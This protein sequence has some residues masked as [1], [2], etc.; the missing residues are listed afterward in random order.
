MHHENQRISH[1]LN[2]YS[3]IE[4]KIDKTEI[5]IPKIDCHTNKNKN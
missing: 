5:L 4:R 1:C 3:M 2:I